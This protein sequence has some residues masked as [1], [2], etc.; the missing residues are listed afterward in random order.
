M[1]ENFSRKLERAFNNYGQLCVGVDPHATLLIDN[2][3]DDSLQGLEEFSSRL[4]E[5]MIGHVGIVK[6]LVSFFERFGSAGL[7]VL[8]NQ[9][10]LAKQEGLLV[11]ADAK[12]GDIGSTMAAYADAWL[13]KDASFICDALTVNPFLG[14][15]SLEPAMAAAVERGK[16]LFVLCATSN[17]EAQ[18][19]QGSMRDGVGL[20]KS[21]ANDVSKFNKLTSQSNSRFGSIGLVVGATVDLLQNE[22]DDLNSEG[23]KLRSPILSPGFGAQGV[24]LTQAKEIFPNTFGDTIFSA[25]R[26]IL[27]NGLAG[28]D[29]TIIADATVLADA[30]GGKI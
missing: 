9:L 7:K 20:S 11:I 22:L 30:L 2:G 19:V 13:G 27:R 18:T 21:I 23:S 6:F 15:G 24:N 26:S 16:G 28:V 25:S 17:P 29:K 8:E 3:I 4:L 1:P 10:S 12:R 5:G 14:V